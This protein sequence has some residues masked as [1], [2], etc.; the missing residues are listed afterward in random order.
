MTTSATLPRS[1]RLVQ[2]M[3]EHSI[4]YRA[5][6]NQL[7]CSYENVHRW[8]YSDIMPTKYHASCVALG[9][10]PELLPAPY[11]RPQGRPTRK[12]CFPG[13]VAS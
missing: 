1:I 5:L 2:W 13:L 11:D 9:F 8:I 10:P 4:T 3:A 12:P 6:A 7:G